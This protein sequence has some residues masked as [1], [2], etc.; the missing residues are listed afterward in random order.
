M[1]YNKLASDPYLYC[2]IIFGYLRGGGGSAL[3]SVIRKHT[4]YNALLLCNDFGGGRGGGGVEGKS[5]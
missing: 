5:D 4:L 2:P 1:Y 3:A